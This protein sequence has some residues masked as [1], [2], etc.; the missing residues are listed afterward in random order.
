M[1][2]S[3]VLTARFAK[4]HEI[5]FLYCVVFWSYEA[6]GSLHI[7]PN[8]EKWKDFTVIEGI[9]LGFKWRGSWKS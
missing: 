2:R 6:A 3:S 5:Y 8:L 4:R 1:E 9:G 7:I